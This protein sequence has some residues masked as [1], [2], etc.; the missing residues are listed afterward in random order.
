MEALWA[1]FL[2]LLMKLFHV[3]E[4]LISVSERSAYL[5]VES[6]QGCL[7]LHVPHF[8]GRA[9]GMMERVGVFRPCASC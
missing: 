3:S 4:F 8:S 7:F 9:P 5:T 1:R 6:R 2:T